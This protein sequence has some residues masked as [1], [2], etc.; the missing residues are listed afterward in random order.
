MYDQILKNAL[1]NIDYVAT[2]TG[3]AKAA[4][5]SAYVDSLW[6]SHSKCSG[7]TGCKIAAAG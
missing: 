7:N 5:V 3:A 4:V 6:W 1:S 2:L